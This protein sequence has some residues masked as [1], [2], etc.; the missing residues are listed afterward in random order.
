[1]INSWRNEKKPGDAISAEEENVRTAYI[2][3]HGMEHL[4]NGEQEINHDSLV[5]AIKNPSTALTYDVNG[6]LIKTEQ[7]ID[8]KTITQDLEYT[9]DLLTKVIKTEGGFQKEKIFT[10]ENEI[11]ISVS[12]WQ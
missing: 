5:N 9:G 8:G 2:I 6:R 3:G 11:L 1:M 7:M 10:Y 12:E 4:A